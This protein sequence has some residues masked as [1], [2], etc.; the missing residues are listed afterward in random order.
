MSTSIWTHITTALVVAFLGYIFIADSPQERLDHACKPVEWVG[1]MTVSLSAL[2]TPGWQTRVK[3]WIANT[4]YAC[5]YVLW[6]QFYEDDYKK[7]LNGEGEGGTGDDD[8]Y[9]APQR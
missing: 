2:T 9:A 8:W 6:R 5:E 7:A 1:N 3:R 4:D